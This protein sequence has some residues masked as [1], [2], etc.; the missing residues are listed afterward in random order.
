MVF[1]KEEIGFVC[2]NSCLTTE[3]TEDTE[4]RDS[5]EFVVLSFELGCGQKTEDR[6]QE[7]GVRSQKTEHRTQKVEFFLFYGF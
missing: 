7:S 4:D 6:R 3:D 1:A 5:F 2:S